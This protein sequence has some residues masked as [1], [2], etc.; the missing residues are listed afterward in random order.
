MKSARSSSLF[1]HDSLL[2]KMI[3]LALLYFLFGR[4]GLL[5]AIPPGYATVIWP[6][7]GISIGMM[8]LYGWQLWP[9]VFIGSFF[10][11]TY[12]AISLSG[13]DLNSGIVL[14]ASCIAIGSTLQAL[15]GYRLTKAFIGLP[16]SFQKIRD[17]FTLLFLTGPVSCLVAPSVGV[18]TLWL[19]QKITADNFI[20][21]WLTWWSGDV[22]GVM[23]F[24]PLVLLSPVRQ[25]KLN[26]RGRQLGK[27]PYFSMLL[28]MLPIGITFYSW[29]LASENNYARA[30]SNFKLL[31]QENEKALLQRLAS[32]NQA[33]L[34]GAGFFSGSDFVSNEEWGTYVSSLQLNNNFKGISGVGFINEVRPEN[35]TRFE[36]RLK[37]DGR[38][39]FTIH[40]KLQANELFIIS[41][42]EPHRANSPALGLN[43]AFEKNRREAALLSK[44]SGTAAITKRILLVQDTTNSPGFLLLYPTYLPNKPLETL[45]QRHE[46]FRGWVYAAFIGKN[47]LADLTKSQGST[48]NLKIY[49]GGKEDAKEL[50]F[51]SNGTS[52][53]KPLFVVSKKIDIFQQ[54]W[55]IEWVSTD[56]FEFSERSN[57]PTFILIGGILFSCLLGAFLLMFAKREE[58]VR[59]LV[60][61]QTKEIIASQKALKASEETFRL[62]IENA[63]VGTALVDPSGKWIRV[64]PALCQL[65]GYTQEELLKTDFQTMT[66]PEDLNRDMEFVAKVLHGDISHYQM[67]KRY[68][69][70]SGRVIWVLLNV[71]LVR[72]NSG[73]P[74][75]FIS[76]IIDM[77]EQKEIERIAHA[78]NIHPW[79]AR[80]D[81]RY[82]VE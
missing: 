66:H 60:D 38:P 67:D 14:F 37:K 20:N 63:A 43:I 49:D 21:T 17:A 8:L 55:L 62:A 32:Y 57:S 80:V 77:S 2:P 70:K 29:K 3:I 59:E 48:L 81:R 39:N 75:Y 30:Y 6:P 50:I 76:Q 5:I 33:L 18:I 46:A 42:V 40:P 28:L 4:L 31:A 15:L 12:I 52:Q 27:L 24:L 54:P 78:V 64:N 7:S 41:Y 61:E 73:V 71:S 23:L 51:D 36:E 13:A 11:N 26:W 10:L 22:F 69:H 25:S 44:D 34:G 79:L 1:T 82:D 9:G 74:Q 53:H 68:F 19:Y 47:S 65:L 35:A 72:D 45:Q 16:L 56:A 58:R